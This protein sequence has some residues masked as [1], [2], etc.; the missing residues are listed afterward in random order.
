MPRSLAEWLLAG[1]SLIAVVVATVLANNN[2][3]PVVDSKPSNLTQLLLGTAVAFACA[4]IAIS[5]DL[6]NSVNT[7]LGALANTSIL[8]TWHGWSS[9]VGRVRSTP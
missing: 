5:T 8:Q 7:R 2:I 6:Q 4:V 3:V 1:G 9:L